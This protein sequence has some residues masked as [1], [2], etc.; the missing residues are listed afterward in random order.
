MEA[1]H[2][3]PDVLGV[4]RS[5]ILIEI[6]IKV[7]LADLKSDAGKR[8]HEEFML[9][10]LR[11]NDCKKYYAVPPA[12]ID[13]AL[14]IIPKEQG[15]LSLRYPV[16]ASNGMPPMDAIK[17]KLLAIRGCTMRPKKR[18]SLVAAVRMAE[19]QSGTLV[20]M[21]KEIARLAAVEEDPFPD[22]QF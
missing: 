15:V 18:I 5:R 17:M 3:R 20:S 1:R 6:E 10:F 16:G 9:N 12:L 11:G 19:N 13:Q 4:M 7:S 14:E 22:P 21:S 2:F 8:R